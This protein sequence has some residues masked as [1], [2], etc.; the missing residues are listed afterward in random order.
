MQNCKHGG[1]HFV[2]SGWGP[3]WHFHGKFKEKRWRVLGFQIFQH[4][5]EMGKSNQQ[6][7]GH[8]LWHPAHPR[9][10][11]Y[12]DKACVWPQI[13]NLNVTMVMKHE[14]KGQHGGSY[15]KSNFKV[16]KVSSQFIG[17]SKPFLPTILRPPGT[18]LSTNVPFRGALDVPVSTQVWAVWAWSAQMSK[19]VPNPEASSNYTCNCAIW[20]HLQVDWFISFKYSSPKKQ[21]SGNFNMI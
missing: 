2:W 15:L 12:Q 5:K 11:Y 1:N 20:C 16:L 17:S 21:G 10:H 3:F 9:A 4:Q 14:I 19:H 8:G 13:V 6:C 7:S 18:S